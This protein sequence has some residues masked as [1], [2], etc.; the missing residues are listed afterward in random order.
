MRLIGQLQDIKQGQRFAAYLITVG[1]PARADESDTEGCEVWIEEEDDLLQ[2]KKELAEFLQQPDASKY[3]NSIPVAQ[4]IRRSKENKKKRIQ[5][6]IVVGFRKLNPR[7]IATLTLIAISVIFTLFT[8]FGESTDTILF[9][10]SVFTKL[11][12][13]QAS[14]IF[15]S[16]NENRD[17]LR[18]RLASIYRGEL[19][20]LVTPI[21]MHAS[22]LHLLFNMYWMFML[23][24]MIEWRYGTWRLL[25]LVLFSAI[26]S[27]L[28]QG[29]VPV[30]YGGTFPTIAFIGE[31]IVASRFYGM[32]GVVYG[33]FGFI[34]TKSVIDP[35]SRL[36]LPQ[37]TIIIMLVWLVFC[38]LPGREAPYLTIELFGFAVANWAHA[39][40]LVVGIAA[41]YLGLGTQK[42]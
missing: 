5:K 42:K 25:L 24:R 31:Q 10:Q 26:F 12:L 8:G 7:P 2:A 3:A 23:G 27:N 11:S 40:G 33:L 16:V 39:I 1:I 37:S 6:K 19:W 20:R 29:T 32:S 17:D 14:S 9:Q 4:K 21:F 35:N 30:Q 22:A 18:F 28:A 13:E 38:M 36:F 41:A 34:W 15:Q